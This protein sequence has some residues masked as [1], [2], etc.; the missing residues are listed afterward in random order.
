MDA[1]GLG[2][3]ID[4]IPFI[5]SIVDTAPQ[6]HSFW[7]CSNQVLIVHV[8]DG[9]GHQHSTHM[10]ACIVAHVELVPSCLLISLQPSNRNS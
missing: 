2:Y 1:E 7:V 8:V 10:G 3:L 6:L 5:S 9:A 4:Q